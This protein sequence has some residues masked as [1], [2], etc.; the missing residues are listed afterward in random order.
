MKSKIKVAVVSIV[1]MIALLFQL[2]GSSE[3]N[4]ASKPNLKRVV[5]VASTT[6]SVS[7]SK[8]YGAKK[9]EIYCAED[10]SKYEKVKETK[11]TNYSFKDLDL[12]TKYSYK[13]RAV[14]K[15]KKSVFSNARNVTTL[16]WAYLLDVAKPYNNPD[17][18][19]ETKFTV[20]G[21]SY[22]RG[23]NTSYC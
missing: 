14:L 22:G 7:W 20:A 12:G 13:V 23:F 11:K 18:Y 10:N 9:Y 6:I 21:D 15:S 3:V 1:L 17:N 16:D 2:A 5:L 19:Y 8:V 4:A